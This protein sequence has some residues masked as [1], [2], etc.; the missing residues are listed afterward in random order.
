[1]AGRDLVIAALLATTLVAS[2][3]TAARGEPLRLGHQSWLAAGPFYIARDKGWF[4]AEGVEVELVAVEDMAVRAA[5]L[6]TGELDAMVATVEETVLHLTP[7][8]ELRLVFA[9][10]DSRGAD[11]LVAA[12]GIDTVSQ[13]AGKRVAMQ[14]G[15]TGQFYL[16]VLLREAGINESELTIVP[17]APGGAGHAFEIGEVDAAVTWEPWLRRARQRERGDVLADTSD[18]P[19]LLITAVVARAAPLERR[20]EEFAALYRAWLRAVAFARDNP[21]E[22]DTIIAA[23]LGHWLRH[24]RIVADMRA[25]I[26]WYDD[27]ANAALFGGPG[28]PGPLAET[29]IRAIEIWDGFGKLQVRV[30]PRQLISYAIVGR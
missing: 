9:V 2:S 19:G 21:D 4:A 12:R 1:M 14:P 27:A 30:R 17:L 20:T 23:G 7:K 15:T 6:A 25:G 3:S 22:A 26:A 10:S 11:G 13:L 5:S 29:L 24:P 8:T 18:R 28:R 16:N